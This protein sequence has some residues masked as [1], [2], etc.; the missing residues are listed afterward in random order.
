M[1]TS[2]TR[3]TTAFTLYKDDTSEKPG[4]S[5]S[6]CHEES[7]TPTASENSSQIRSELARILASEF[8]SGS[9]RCREFLSYIV[10]AIC[11]GTQGELKERTI[12]VMVFGRKP[13]YDTGADAIVRVK[14]S[15][16]RRRLTQYNLTAPANR[17]VIIDLR[18]GSYVPIIIRQ[19]VPE[20]APISVQLTLAAEPRR[21]NA[22]RLFI[23]AAAAM[24]VVIFLTTL[25]MLTSQ[26]SPIAL[27]W[28]P[29]IH[30][31]QP[32]ICTAFP[33]VYTR[34]PS[35][36][37]DVSDTHTAFLIQD[38]LQHFGRSSRVAVADDIGASEIK[39]S[40][41][42]LIGGPRTNRWTM[43][44]TKDLRFSFSDCRRQTQDRRS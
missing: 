21:S 37:K 24:L 17:A 11:R 27:F 22:K 42:V 30:L 38:Q 12:G 31:R 14:A 3:A 8:F 25:H 5:A 23:A 26:R 36:I 18:P 13:D 6:R 41:I 1:L 40:P 4:A 15:E 16:I 44:M 32:I 2:P 7:L 28:N 10:E 34:I 19:S 33:S 29:Y 39:A 35:R 9:K 43:S 20:R